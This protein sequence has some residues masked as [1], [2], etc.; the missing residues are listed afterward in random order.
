MAMELIRPN[1]FSPQRLD[2]QPLLGVK[3]A[4]WRLDDEHADEADTDFARIKSAILT[5]QAFTCQ[6]CAFR[7]AKYQEIHHFNDDHHDNSAE[8]LLTTC[9][10]CHQV[11]HL[12]MAGM[13]ASGFMAYIP[14][15]T[16][17][18][19]NHL[20]R[21]HFVVCASV[22]AA[23]ETNKPSRYTPAH[24]EQMRALYASFQARGDRL[25]LIFNIDISSP[26][27]F[28]NALS[29]LMSSEQYAARMR[30]LDGLRLVATAAAFRPGQLDYYGANLPT[31]AS[32]VGEW[33]ARTRTLIPET[34]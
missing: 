27:C 9:N 3:R 30:V 32:G 31:Y 7:A 21:A 24:Q 1:P 29:S 5:N 18:E 15:L 8:N 13:N 28:V 17:V 34:S 23:R 25:K 22:D 12:G 2:S 11:H 4:K 26:S 16:Q 19:I 14:E 6:F 20:V 10:L 33:Q